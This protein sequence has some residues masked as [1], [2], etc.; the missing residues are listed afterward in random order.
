MTSFQINPHPSK[1]YDGSNYVDF[2][3]G[4]TINS[5][6]PK[7]KGTSTGISSIQ[8]LLGDSQVGGNKI[9][10]DGSFIKGWKGDPL[11]DGTYS[12]TVSD[13]NNPETILFTSYI[14]IDANRDN[15]PINAQITKV[16]VDT[17]YVPFKP[18]MTIHTDTPKFR[19]TSDGIDSVKVM[20]NGNQ[21]G[22]NNIRDGG[23]FAKGWKG[24]PLTDGK[25]SLTVSDNNDPE[26]ILF[27][28]YIR[29]QNPTS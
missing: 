2:T 20:I 10:S 4:M 8:I 22:G 21:V 13:N 7:F 12:L 3:D 23:I 5:G 15:N 29:I 1:S 25:Y 27:T 18:G 14:I 9:S 26:T 16:R 17:E 6:T 19:G 24:D 28:S 11:A